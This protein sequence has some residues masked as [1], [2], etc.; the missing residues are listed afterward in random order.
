M[1]G[2]IS[3]RDGETQ[4][5]EGREEEKKKREEEKRSKEISSCMK[6]KYLESFWILR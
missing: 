6:M 4:R 5:R 1:R 2:R 3:R